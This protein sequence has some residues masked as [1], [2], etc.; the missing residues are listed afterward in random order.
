[1]NE[2]LSNDLTHRRKCV[3]YRHSK[4]CEITPSKYCIVLV[5]SGGFYSVD[6]E[7]YCHHINDS[8]SAL[9]DIEFQLK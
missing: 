8:I 1:M 3:L 2:T 6:Y 7:M 5:Y 9:Y 4:L